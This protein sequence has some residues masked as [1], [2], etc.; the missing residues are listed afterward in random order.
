MSK[1]PVLS[2]CFGCVWWSDNAG[3]F[4]GG[5][6]SPSDTAPCPCSRATGWCIL[7][8]SVQYTF[9]FY[10]RWM[11]KKCISCYVSGKGSALLT[12]ASAVG[13]TT[14]TL[15]C[16]L[17]NVDVRWVREDYTYVAWLPYKKSVSHLEYNIKPVIL[18]QKFQ[19]CKKQVSPQTAGPSREGCS[20]N[21][22]VN[23]FVLVSGH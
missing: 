18:G 4:A 22:Q 5:K 6:H 13:L 14:C 17:T 12:L 23:A 2:P 9:S 10:H 11:N 3:Q 7:I 8:G 21:I 16:D 1:T 15:K 20:L 19:A